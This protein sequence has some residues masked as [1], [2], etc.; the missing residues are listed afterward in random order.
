MGCDPQVIDALGLLESVAKD[1]GLPLALTIHPSVPKEVIG[2][3]VRLRQVLLNLVRWQTGNGP[4]DCD[5]CR[6]YYI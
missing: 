4:A 2:D 1:K 6:Q 5:R 3:P